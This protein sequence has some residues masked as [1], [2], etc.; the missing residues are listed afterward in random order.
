MGNRKN[1]S[2]NQGQ[3]FSRRAFLVRSGLV[4]AGALSLPALLAACGDDSSS[5]TT[6]PNGSAATKTLVFDNW[7]EYIDPETATAFAAFSGVNFTYNEGF[8]DNN[9]Y[10][11]K[12]LPLLSQGKTIDADILAPTFWMAQRMLGLGW[13]QKLDLAKIPNAANLRSDLKDP[14]WDEGN[15]YSLP[16]Q[17]G[18]AG[19]AYNIKATGRE[20]TSVEDLFAPEFKGKVGMLTEMRDTLGLVLL[21]LGQKLDEIT[22]FDQA[23]NGF[24]KIEKAKNDGQIRQFTG[25]DY[26]DDL[27]LGN[28]AVCVGW[29]GDVL[30]LGKD[31]PDVRF[32]IP[33]EGGTSWYDTMVLMKGSPNGDAVAEFMNYVY[34]P[35]NAA[36]ITAFVQYMSPVEGVRD[37]LIKLGGDATAL[38]DNTLLF[39]DDATLARL[40]SWGSL[41]EEEEAKFDERFSSI[42]GA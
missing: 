8:N 34:D 42:I 7:P 39:P 36:R 4:G 24:D 1:T 16:W 32:V 23:A 35:V 27:S 5:N 40:Q 41:S 6:S 31:N 38:A 13:L 26:I 11:A 2:A 9:E 25:N 28:F 18:V 17:T 12:I 20:I 10:F 22:T 37:E 15:Q 19:L 3:A 33:E 30:Q 14:A 29:S 21:G